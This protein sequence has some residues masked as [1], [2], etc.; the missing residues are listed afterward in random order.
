MNNFFFD[1][2][3]AGS[4]SVVAIPVG[5][6]RAPDM[7]ESYQC[8]LKRARSTIEKPIPE[9]SIGIGISRLPARAK[10]ARNE[11]DAQYCRI[12]TRSPPTTGVCGGIL[13][14][15]VFLNMFEKKPSGQTKRF[16]HGTLKARRDWRLNDHD[17]QAVSDR[18]KSHH[19][20]KT[21]RQDQASPSDPA[22]KETAQEPPE[23]QH[24][25]MCNQG[26]CAVGDWKA[27]EPA[28]PINRSRHQRR[29]PQHLSDLAKTTSEKKELELPLDLSSMASPRDSRGT[30]P[31]I[32]R[33]P[34]EPAS[35]PENEIASDH[36][37]AAE[38]S[39]KEPVMNAELPPATKP[40]VV[41]SKIATSHPSV[42]GIR[43]TRPPPVMTCDHPPII[44]NDHMPELQ[45]FIG[46]RPASVEEMIYR[47]FIARDRSLC[48]QMRNW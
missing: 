21:D 45:T 16:S 35:S 6:Q 25:R 36:S 38:S 41:E 44:I 32:D 22:S 27:G 28:N 2:R 24:R 12:A 20:D 5:K 43:P 19:A 26:C 23:P 4:A 9:V 13:F 47:Q 11:P 18:A 46:T 37:P 34:C 29:K 10:D 30:E 15:H 33:Q 40:V 8:E 7:S 17:S 42:S 3:S 31:A 48:P 39:V 14:G 1:L